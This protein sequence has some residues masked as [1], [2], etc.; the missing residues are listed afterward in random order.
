MSRDNV[1]GND[2]TRGYVGNEMNLA[3]P[4]Q[5]DYDLRFSVMGFPVRVHPL[6]WLVSAILGLFSAASF[7]ELA[8]PFVVVLI[9]VLVVFVAVLVHE[10]GHAV[11]MR[12]FGENAR[13]VL[14]AMGGLAIRDGISW[15]M[16]AS[17]PRDTKSQII[18]SF[19]GPLAGFALAI[20]TLGFVEAAGGRISFSVSRE[21]FFIPSWDIALERGVSLGETLASNPRMIYVWILIQSILF[22]NIYW[23]IINLFPVFPLDG[24][25]IARAAFVHYDPWQGIIRSLWLS[26]I[27]AGIVAAVGFVNGERFLG[28]M[29]A[30]LAVS[31]FQAIQQSGRGRW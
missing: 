23:G 4:G 2:S 9:W 8:S 22:V 30:M 26:V 16:T 27:F 12:Y 6:F 14:Y 13:V 5:T 3:E 28:F 1:L 18:I 19:A 15:S 10:I 25:Q 20:L 7:G 11:A 29:F 31:S 17:K 21:T 24:G